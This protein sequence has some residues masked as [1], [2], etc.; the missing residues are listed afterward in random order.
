MYCA[1][2]AALLISV[3]CNFTM[4]QL[5]RFL[6][7]SASGVPASHMPV[8]SSFAAAAGLGA[9]FAERAGGL[10]TAA[11]LVV[12]VAAVGGA[13]TF[14]CRWTLA[15]ASE[16]MIKRLRDRL[17]SHIQRL[18]FE[19]HIS[20]QTGD[21]VQRC[22]S[23][24]E[25]VRNFASNQLIEII[26]ASALVIFAYSVLFPM[27]FTMAAASF[28][29]LP[30]IFFYSAV[31]LRNASV[32]FL[33]AD[34][35]EGLLLA[36]A[37]ENFSG[38]RVVRAFGRERY[39]ADRFAAQ[40]E[41]F[42]ELWMK[43]GRM[44]SAYWG[45]GD[46]LTGLQMVAI[47]AVGAQQASRGGITVGEFIVFIIYNSMIIWP[48]RGLGRVLSEAGKTFV[49]L[50]RL[51]EILESPTEADDEGAS[52]LPVKGDIEFDR[53]SFSYQDEPVLRDVS[54]TVKEGTTLGI[55]GTTGSGKTTVA[56][57]LCRLYDLG[58][59]E[60]EIRIGKVDIK[61]F[62]HSHLRSNVGVV[63]QEPFLY[64]RTIA[65]NIAGLSKNCPIQRIKDA[66]EIAQVDSD[67][68]R[69]AHSYGTMVGERGVTLSGGQKQRVAI[70]RAILKGTPIMVFD[71][72]LS[73]V[74][75]ETDARIR[76]ALKSR[77][78]GVTFIIIS[79]RITTLSQADVIMVM[80][81]GRIVEMGPPA[82]LERQGGIYARVLGMQRLVE[83]D[84][85]E[86]AG[87]A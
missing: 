75:T 69:F 50:G 80:E 52:E 51:R 73:A 59:G 47:C 71:D 28:A 3:A 23:D 2:C 18:P 6:V 29:F 41:L 85:A 19:W 66:A 54:F 72:S 14:T 7:D 15:C 35:A 11:L 76:A 12:A 42:A 87:G 56:H 40:N 53:V 63:L 62:K 24:V 48:V 21:I 9:D 8:I 30:V 68:E 60:G 37:Q 22:T 32:S 33:A 81:S 70:A 74:D 77:A 64:S 26:R 25:I 83:G 27:N 1:A 44:L 43:L 17:Y 38:V 86:E 58:D 39:E 78:G 45:I 10:A 13:F 49:S 31:F 46:L 67:I 36:I 34:E 84:L 79:H 65:E 4:P 55:L 82:E 61:R 20:I 5:I 16:G 57:L